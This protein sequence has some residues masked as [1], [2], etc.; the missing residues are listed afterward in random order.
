MSDSTRYNV[1]AHL[2]ADKSRLYRAILVEFARAKSRFVIHLRPS[3]V[4]QALR[5]SNRLDAAS[6][7][8]SA[9]QQ[10]VD[11][12]NLESHP[13]TSEVATVEDF[14]RVRNLYQISGA[15]EAAEQAIAVFEQ[16]IRQPGEL[17]SAALD[18]IRRHLVRIA[19]ISTGH[20]ADDTEVANVFSLIRQRF[21]E[22]TVQAQRFM[23]GIQR[24]LTF[25]PSMSNRF[26]P[27][28]SV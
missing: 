27:T 2:T 10:L 6:L 4:E 25:N 17:Q 19:A 15:G 21:D 13:D 9:L 14:W 16:S 28:S 23:G 5:T 3:D 26:S 22:L 7:S 24:R 11:W 18:D 1:F 12:G 20:E 8:E